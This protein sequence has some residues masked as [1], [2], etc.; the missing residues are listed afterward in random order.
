MRYARRR[1]PED[2]SPAYLGRSGARPA[3]PLPAD[4]ISGH[5]DGNPRAQPHDAAGACAR[6]PMGGHRRERNSP[7]RGGSRTV[8]RSPP[9]PPNTAPDPIGR[10]MGP[11]PMP[12]FVGGPEEKRSRIDPRP[13]G[14]DRGGPRLIAGCP[15][16]G[17]DRNRRERPLLGALAGVFSV[18]Y[19]RARIKAHQHRE[20]APPGPALFFGLESS[21]H[22]DSVHE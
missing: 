1:F 17:A 2:S 3:Q 11:A 9:R 21:R 13:M 7:R 8:P 19:L 5:R 16:P 12:A 10:A 4:A 14:I 18:C 20:R 22:I 6:R 15:S